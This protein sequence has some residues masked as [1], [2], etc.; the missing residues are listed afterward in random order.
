MSISPAW[1]AAAEV[2]ASVIQR[3]STRSKWPDLGAAEQARRAR[4]RHVAVEAA[5]DG[6]RAREPFLRHEAIGAGAHDLGEGARRVHG[7]EALG[8]D[9]AGV[10]ARLAQ[11]VQHRAEA[12]GQPDLEAAVVQRAHLRRALAQRLAERVARRP[13]RDGGDGVG[14]ADAFAV[15]EADALAE[16]EHPAQPVILHHMPLAE[17][18]AHREALIR[19]VQRVPA[20]VAVVAHA[21]AGRAHRI[22]RGDV[23][24]RDEPQRMRRRALAQRGRAERE[25][26]GGGKA[27]KQGAAAHAVLG[28]QGLAM[29]AAQHGACRAAGATG[30][31]L[32]GGGRQG[33][34]GYD[35]PGP[36][37]V[38]L[39]ASCRAGRAMSDLHLAASP[40]TWG[41]ATWRPIVPMLA[42]IIAFLVATFLVG[43]LQS[44]M[45]SRLEAARAPAALVRE[46]TAC[47]AAATPRL[48]E[49]AVADP[50]WAVTT[51]VGAWIGT[52]APEAA[53]RDAAPG[54]APAIDAARPYLARS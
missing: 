37:G 14:G 35:G 31:V 36:S 46:V 49:R 17:L 28:S 44:E 42:D 38:V 12:G 50:W 47:A 13:A 15:V 21:I 33:H 53:L 32:E 39:L 30:P 11:R 3:N 26:R 54:C 2:P 40:S 27:G 9:E 25:G 51:A 8:V 10:G 24:V 23:G 7:R 5:I 48:A 1:I 16:R 43:P 4:V 34:F 29:W 45:A 20:H 18:R 41:A 22:E 6:P 52:T 19:A